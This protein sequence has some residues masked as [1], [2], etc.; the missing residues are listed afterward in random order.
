MTGNLKG[1]VAL[2]TGAGQGIGEGI[3][4]CFAGAGAKVVIATRTA[5]NGNAVAKAIVE[6]GAREHHRQRCRTRLHTDARDVGARQ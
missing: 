6:T 1:R 3:A 2:I 5:S 4:R